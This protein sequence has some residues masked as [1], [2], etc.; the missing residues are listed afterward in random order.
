MQ[1][2]H[3]DCG[4]FRGRNL[5]AG[6]AERSNPEDVLDLLPDREREEEDQEDKGAE[7]DEEAD[8]RPPQLALVLDAG[9]A[10]RPG[11]RE[12]ARDG[13]RVDRRIVSRRAVWGRGTDGW[14]F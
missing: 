2:L 4:T 6:V 7:E 8:S 5:G 11:T 13:S 12:A 1:G 10:P 14:R 3:P 9:A